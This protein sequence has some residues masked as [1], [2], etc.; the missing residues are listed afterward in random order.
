MNDYK[1]IDERLDLDNYISKV[2]AE[3]PSNDD[4]YNLFF[5]GK[6]SCSEHFLASKGEARHFGMA[7]FSIANENEIFREELEMAY[8]AIIESK[9]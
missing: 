3:Y 4:D 8:H 1:H 2:V 9:K 6:E 5:R 7:L